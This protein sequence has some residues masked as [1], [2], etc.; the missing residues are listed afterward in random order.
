MPTPRSS[1]TRLVVNADDLGLHPAID[2]GILKAH[3]DGIVTSATVLVT[4]RSAP[5]AIQRARKQG[6]A[7]G[8]HLCLSTGLT[9]VLPAHEVPSLAPKGR[10]R[11]SWAHV[12]L[13]WARGQLRAS[14]VARELRAQVA[15]ARELGAAVD[16][17]DAHQHLHVLPGL[18]GLVR[19]LAAEER[20]PLR[21]P[22]ERPSI[23]WLGAPGAAAKAVVLGAL[24]HLP[25]RRPERSVR[26][27]GIFESGSLDEVALLRLVG[28]L[29]PGDWE[30][31][32]HPGTHPGSVPED[33]TWTYG[34]EGE[35][36]ALCSPRACEALQLRG[37]QLTTYASLFAT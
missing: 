17:L 32:C 6:L 26:A 12:A 9:P 21:W 18:S 31:V 20:L 28:S 7:L 11:P 19:Q 37:V 35:L 1:V 14:E 3:R 36:A 4:G 13:A 33:P 34:W 25:K 15:R 27:V 8:V 29:G 16:H 5:N 22:Q 10:F 23:Q 2:E 30:L 24:S